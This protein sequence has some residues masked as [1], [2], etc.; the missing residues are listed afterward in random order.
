VGAGYNVMADFAR[1]GQALRTYVNVAD[2]VTITEGSVS[3]RDLWVDIIFMPRA[4]P[5]IVD[6]DE[7]IASCAAGLVSQS[8]T[9][10]VLAFARS[11]AASDAPLFRPSTIENYLD[12][13]T[14]ETPHVW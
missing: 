14:T 12:A 13:L 3:W 2:A 7:L 10:R 11:I 5:E 9:K 4:E 6:E 8:A 1:D